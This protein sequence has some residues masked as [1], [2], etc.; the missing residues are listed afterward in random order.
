MQLQHLVKV[1]VIREQ[2]SPFEKDLWSM[3]LGPSLTMNQVMS[4]SGHA[5]AEWLGIYSQLWY[6][7]I[8]QRLTTVHFNCLEWR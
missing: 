6:F 3:W 1:Y 7:D 8:G 4:E 5:A 2:L